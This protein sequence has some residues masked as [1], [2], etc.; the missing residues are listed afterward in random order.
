M[1]VSVLLGIVSTWGLAEWLLF[2]IS[3]IPTIVAIAII[4]MRLDFEQLD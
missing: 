3:L 1:M 2:V 4:W